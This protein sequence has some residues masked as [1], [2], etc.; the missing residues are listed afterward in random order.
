M[1]FTAFLISFSPMPI[2]YILPLNDK[3]VWDAIQNGE[4]HFEDD[5]LND[6]CEDCQSS[7][8]TYELALQFIKYKGWL[9]EFFLCYY[10]Q[11]AK[12]NDF[13]RSE[14]LDE[15][16]CKIYEFKHRE[17]IECCKHNFF[18]DVKSYVLDNIFDWTEFLRKEAIEN[19]NTKD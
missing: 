4:Y 17:D 16:F 9:A 5:L 6:V 19:E 18:D 14:A 13:E 11:I 15:E 8:V 2:R 12:V 1:S 10:Y 7:K 3:K